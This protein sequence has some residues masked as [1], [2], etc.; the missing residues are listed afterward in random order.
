MALP[1][2]APRNQTREPVVKE[3]QADGTWT[4]LPTT[5]VTFDDIKVGTFP[6]LYFGRNRH[7]TAKGEL[8]TRPTY[9]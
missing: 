6:K 1:H 5:D 7:I 8:D 3:R 9:T 4:E 2:C